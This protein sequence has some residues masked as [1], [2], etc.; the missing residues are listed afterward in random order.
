MHVADGSKRIDF[1]VSVSLPTGTTGPV[2]I[3]IGLG[4]S[5]L[6]SAIVKGEGVATGT[7]NHQTIASETSRSG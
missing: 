6:D 3:I 1:S 4:G 7:Y 2:P 5:S